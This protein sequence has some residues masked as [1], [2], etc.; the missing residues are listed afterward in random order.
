[1]TPI[2][3]KSDAPTNENFAFCSSLADDVWHAQESP[4]SYEWW[5]F[6]ALSDDGRDALVII[7][8]DNFVF[9]PRYNSLC[10]ANAKSK[11]QTSNSQIQHFPAISFCLYRDG[12]PLYRAINETTHDEFESS[13][14][15]PFC[16]IGA[17]DF[18]FEATPYGVR[19]ILNVTAN[20]RGGKKIKAALEWLVLERDYH[21][22]ETSKKSLSN[23]HLWNLASPRSDVTGKVEVFN[24]GGKQLDE[25]QF[26][27]TG[28]HD[29]NF[30]SRWL[31]ATVKEWQWGRAHFEDAT[32]IF[33][34]YWEINARAPISKV[35]LI[36]SDTLSQRDCALETA[37]L[38]RNHFGIVFPRTLKFA[39][40]EDFILNVTQRKT[41]DASFFYLRFLSDMELDLGD[42]TPR[43]AVGITEHLAPR[44]LRWR[45]LDWLINM[46]IGRNGRGAF[47]P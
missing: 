44:S 32:A 16:R 40:G 43:R 37:K 38:S 33:Y 3:K 36:K 22:L 35:F 34:R 21:Q 26:R 8:L 27:G 19:Y 14:E 12:K 47:L 11:N 7:F 18:R 39:A 20:L 25:I 42:G 30:D 15:F 4:Q 31:P 46:R 17:S 6:D 45:A 10:A 13:T 41:I 23:A 2:R 9:S 24:S 29:H 1:M 28:Y 5:Y